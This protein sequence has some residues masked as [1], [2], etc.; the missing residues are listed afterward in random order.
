[1]AS[2]FKVVARV[3][4]EDRRCMRGASRCLEAIKPTPQELKKIEAAFQN[5]VASLEMENVLK[6][7]G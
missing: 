4:H 1:M 6:D 5:C 2:L 3:C 7:F